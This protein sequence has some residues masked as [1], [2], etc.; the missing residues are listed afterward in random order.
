[1]RCVDVNV[2]VYAHRLESPDH[3]LYREWLDAARK[4]NEPLGLSDLV[5]SGFLRV[6]THPR[7]FREPTPIDV[8]LQFIDALKSSPATT[9]F[10][11]GERHWEIFI[12]LCRRV[13]AKGNLIPDAF[14]A[15]MAIE[16]GTTWVSADRGIAR[17]PDL[18][19]LHPL[20]G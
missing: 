2:L 1:M 7:I 19:L 16:H 14:L 6:V 4:G 15:A 12:D 17:F 8:A 13:G 18:R 10:F 5:A 3:D 20:E 11:P 9:S